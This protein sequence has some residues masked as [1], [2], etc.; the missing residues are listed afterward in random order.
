MRHYTVEFGVSA[1]DLTCI[2][3][4][5]NHTAYAYIFVCIKTIVKAIF[6]AISISYR[7]QIMPA[8]QDDNLEMT[9]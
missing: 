5:N 4:D 9:V 6:F 8:K 1:K 2:T 3:L 7:N